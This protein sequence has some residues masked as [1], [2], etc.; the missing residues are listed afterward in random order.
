[1]SKASRAFKEDRKLRN[2]VFA[3][4]VFTRKEMTLKAYRE[5]KRFISQD[6]RETRKCNAKYDSQWSGGDKY[7]L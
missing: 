6:N 3:T 4:T 2:Y 5:V 7:K 1:M